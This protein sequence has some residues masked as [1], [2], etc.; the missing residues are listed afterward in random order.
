[1][2]YPY[3]IIS[4]PGVTVTGTNG[5]ALAQGD[6]VTGSAVRDIIITQNNTTR[7]VYTARTPDVN[8]GSHMLQVNI[9]GTWTDAMEAD[10]GDWSYFLITPGSIADRATIVFKNADA[11]EVAFQW[12]AYS[13]VSFSGGG[14]PYR[15]TR[16]DGAQG[17]NYAQGAVNPNWK[18]ITSIKLVKTIR[19]QRGEPGYYVGWHS[20]PY[21]G[22][23]DHLI[24]SAT[25][26][27][28]DYGERELGLGGGAAVNW[29]SA[30]RTARWPAWGDD[31]DGKWTAQGLQATSNKVWFP[32]IK[33]PRYTPF[34][35]AAWIAVQGGSFP[36]MQSTGPYYVGD[37]HYSIP[38]AKILAMRIP[39]E[40]FVSKIGVYGGVI[41]HHNNEDHSPAGVPYR[42]QVFIGARHYVADSSSAYANE[43]TQYI[44]DWAS[45]LAES[46][47]WPDA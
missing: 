35:S 21:I 30:S 1:M 7:V 38:V 36:Q 29:S 13:L 9:S 46:L 6:V 44:Q 24:D 32:G 28:T 3:N 14:Q 34:N 40:I 4:T 45:D 17:L 12:D 42:H 19:V 15:D 43:P 10:Q 31:V 20:N 22:L 2:S 25:E 23:P 47:E 16:L 5:A 39:R 37:L 33:D 26:E 11:C 41:S 18:L 8:R 27:T